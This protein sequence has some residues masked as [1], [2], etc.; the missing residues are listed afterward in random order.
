LGLLVSDAVAA[1]ASDGVGRVVAVL[2]RPLE[3]PAVILAGWVAGDAGLAPASL[4]RFAAGGSVDEEDEAALDAR[5]RVL[6][7]RMRALGQRPVRV[8]MTP[9]VR[10][11]AIPVDIAG[12]ALLAELREHRFSRVPVHRGERDNVV[13]VVYAKDL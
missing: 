9:R 10:V 12:V 2:R 11:V 6:I 5:G 13:G 3:R 1:R 4:L 7:E 8:V